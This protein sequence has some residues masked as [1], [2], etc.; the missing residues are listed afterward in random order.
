MPMFGV[1]I[2]KK[3]KKTQTDK[4]HIVSMLRKLWLWSPERRLALKRANGTCENCG[5][6]TKKPHVHHVDGINWDTIVRLIRKHIVCNPDRLLVLCQK[7][8]KREHEK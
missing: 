4:K 3:K 5:C 1:D 8:H 7:C 6:K 2:M